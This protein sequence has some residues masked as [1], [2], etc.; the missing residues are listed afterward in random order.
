MRTIEPPVSSV[1]QHKKFLS[2][3]GGF[4][5]FGFEED[6]ESENYIF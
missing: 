4:T 6:V 5:F 2:L 1:K 3:K